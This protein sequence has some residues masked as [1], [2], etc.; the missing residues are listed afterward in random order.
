M[1]EEE[2]V[3]DA[4]RIGCLDEIDKSIGFNFWIIPVALFCGSV[5]THMANPFYGMT[6]GVL[7]GLAVVALFV[8]IGFIDQ[9]QGDT[10]KHLVKY[11]AIGPINLTY[12]KAMQSKLAEVNKIDKKIV[13]DWAEWERA[14]VTARQHAREEKI[15]FTSSKFIFPEPKSE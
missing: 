9:N 2:S 14:Q 1:S 6:V 13:K 7:A 15:S 5:F 12:M 3:L 10:D 4:R 11:A 8:V